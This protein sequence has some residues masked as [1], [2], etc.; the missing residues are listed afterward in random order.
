VADQTENKPKRRIRKAETVRELSAKAVS[1]VNETPSRGRLLWRGFTAPVR[2][3]GRGFAKLG[4]VLGKFKVM[5]VIGRIL[6]PRYFRNSWKELRLVT[7]PGFK[8]SRQLTGAVILFA[9]IFG[10]VVALLDFGL[11]KVF[12]EVLLK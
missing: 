11:D 2:L 1:P 8:Q 4:R 3:L 12:K 9:V 5:R 7:W 10:V 6:L